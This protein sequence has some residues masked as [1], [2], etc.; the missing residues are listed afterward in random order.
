[1]FSK[2]YYNPSPYPAPIPIKLHYSQTA[3][4]DTGISAEFYYPIKLH[5]SQ[6]ALGSLSVN[7]W[8][9]YPIKLH[10]SQT[11]VPEV[12]REALFYYPIKL[13]YAQT[14]MTAGA[15]AIWFYYPKITGKIEVIEHIAVEQP[16]L[17]NITVCRYLSVKIREDNAVTIVKGCVCNTFLT[18]SKFLAK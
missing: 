12:D 18:T 10:Y 7:N 5:Y 8:F 9:Y 15:I 13:H 6:T 17:S 11:N 16:Q 1:M 4:A 2:F 14:L 3:V